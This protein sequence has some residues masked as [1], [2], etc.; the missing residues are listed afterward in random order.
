MTEL[1]AQDVDGAIRDRILTLLDSG[2]VRVDE[3]PAAVAIPPEE[4]RHV[5]DWP[6]KVQAIAKTLREEGK[7]GDT[8][9]HGHPALK[10]TGP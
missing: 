6:A 3:L 7:I 2:P 9:E 8:E 4:R 1:K 5:A 10:R